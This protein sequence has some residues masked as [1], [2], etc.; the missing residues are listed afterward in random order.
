MR[1]RREG[2]AEKEGIY[3]CEKRL[4]EEESSKV[5]RK[6]IYEARLF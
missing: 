3:C 4:V 2:L 6:D 1:G 5:G